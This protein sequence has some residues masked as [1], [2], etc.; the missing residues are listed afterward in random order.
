M[1]WNARDRATPFFGPLHEATFHHEQIMTVDEVVDRFRSV[2][3][4]AVLDDAP[5]QVVLDEVR[6]LLAIH[7]DTMGRAR[8]AI[9]YR[10]DAYWCERT[11]G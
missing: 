3:H 4:V 10:V 1:G 8:V 9:P 7:P 5:K 6:D 11:S 2:S